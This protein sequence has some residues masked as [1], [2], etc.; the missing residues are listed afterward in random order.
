MKEIDFSS[1]TK[2]EVLYSQLQHKIDTR[3]EGSQDLNFVTKEL[4]PSYKDAAEALD[5]LLKFPI[6]VTGDYVIIVGRNAALA[7]RILLGEDDPKIPVE[8]YNDIPNFD[9][10]NADTRELVV[11]PYAVSKDILKTR[12]RGLKEA[13]LLWNV[14]HL[15]DEGYTKDEVAKALPVLAKWR[16]DKLYAK[17]KGIWTQKAL[18]QARAEVK[19]LTDAKK[20]VNHARIIDRVGLPAKY[21]KDLTDPTRRGARSAAFNALKSKQKL[22]P[23]SK[24]WADSNFTW[25]TLSATGQLATSDFPNKT[26]LSSKAFLEITQHHLKE[27]QAHV[28]LWTGAL[29]RANTQVQRLEHPVR[30][31]VVVPEPVPAKGKAKAKAA[32]AGR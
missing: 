18:A 3:A 20:P 17:A 13:D 15:V 12:Q 27:A 11:R 23:N 5:A 29:M 1:R 8:I 24:K 32:G 4:I 26:L 31:V 7:L 25:Y 19:A 21:I 16:V 30:T 9:K 14:Q 10:L 22:S 2:A 28:S 6:E